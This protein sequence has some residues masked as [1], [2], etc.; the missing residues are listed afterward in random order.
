[1]IK[2]KLFV[3]FSV[4]LSLCVNVAI[5]AQSS[6]AIVLNEYSASNIGTPVDNYGQQSDWVEIRNHHTAQVNLAGYYLSNDRNNLFK[7]KFPGGFLMGVETYSV[8][9]LS[10]RNTVTNGNYHANF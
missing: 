1:M 4:F 10:G 3:V 8:V 9:W 6:T 5:K 7:W 2:R